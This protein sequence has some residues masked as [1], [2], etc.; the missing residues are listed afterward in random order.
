MNPLYRVWWR[1]LMDLRPLVRFLAERLPKLAP[2]ARPAPRR[3]S[4]GSSATRSR[5]SSSSTAPAALARLR[6]AGPLAR[7]P[8]S[9][10]VCVLME[11]YHRVGFRTGALVDR[12]A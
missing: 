4:T 11:I 5:P 12:L 10:V 1:F 8:S 3:S 9:L 7:S 6:L 2:W